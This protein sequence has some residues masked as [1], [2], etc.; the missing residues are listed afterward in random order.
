MV[1]VAAAFFRA[2]SRPGLTI[3]WRSKADTKIYEEA[4]TNRLFNAQT[5][6]RYPLAVVFAKTA[7]DIVDTINLA[8]ERK[9]RISTSPLWKN[10]S[11]QQ[12]K[13]FLSPI[14]YSFSMFWEGAPVLRRFIISCYDEY[15][16]LLSQF[17]FTCLLITQ[18]S[19]GSDSPAHICRCFSQDCLSHT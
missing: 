8:K 2:E 15:C 14:M 4:R 11:L 13:Q 17:H 9:C 7:S 18:T 6:D 10:R 5:P 12:T 3:I 1:Q 16:Y 19:H